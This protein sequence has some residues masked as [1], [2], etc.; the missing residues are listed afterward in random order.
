MRKFL[1][2]FLLII[3]WPFCVCADSSVIVEG[4]TEKIAVTNHGKKSE[5]FIELKV[6]NLPENTALKAFTIAFSK[7]REIKI[8]AVLQDNKSADF[9]FK[10]NALQVNFN[11][12]KSANSKI[13]LYFSYEEIYKKVDKF[14]RQEIIDIPPFA[15]GAK[16]QIMFEFPGSFESATLNPNIIKSG[17]SF[18]YNNIVPPEGVK[19]IIKITPSQSSWNVIVEAKISS[20]KTLKKVS[21]LVPNYFKSGSQQVSDL[22]VRPNVNSFRERFEKGKRVFDFSGNETSI[23][24]LSSAK[25]FTGRNNRSQIIRNPANYLSVSQSDSTLLSPILAFIKQDKKNDNLPLYARIGKFVHEF[26]HYD[27]SYANKLPS[28]AE[29]LQ[30]RRGVCTEFAHLYNSLAR[31]AG[32]PSVIIDGAACGEYDSCRG[33]AWNM[34]Y[35][36]NYWIEVDPTW[37]LMSGVVSSSHVYLKDEGDEDVVIKYLKES[38]KIHSEVNL[39]MKNLA[40]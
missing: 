30:N 33:H 16:A 8:D 14:L 15:K 24:I 13:G 5:V 35:Y 34:I 19:E 22:V 1:Q 10:D 40:L 37:D 28:L 21:A 23:S 17:N 29:I 38:G 31:L 6:G 12:A 9:S 2:L 18:I 3:L 11:K 36:N 27:I 32:I 39:T 4:W 7:N 20:D 26:L 25:I